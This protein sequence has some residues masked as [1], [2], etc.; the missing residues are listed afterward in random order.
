M[1]AVIRWFVAA[2][3]LVA[4]L[5]A[6]RPSPRP[7]GPESADSLRRA[8]NARVREHLAA[9][10]AAPSAHEHAAPAHAAA[11]AAAPAR[12]A[13]PAAVPATA[14]ALAHAGP[15]RAPEAATVGSLH[16]DGAETAWATWKDLIDGN[17]RFAQGKASS[18]PLVQERE[19][20]RAGQHPRA[21]V[22]GCADSRCP[23][24]LLFDQSLGDLFVV[25]TAGN[26]ADPVA[27]G[28]LEYAVEHLGVHLLVVLGH[29]ACGA[30]KATI[31]GGELP[32]D[33]LRAIVDHISPAVEAA[34]V[35]WAG[36]ELLDH[37][38]A[39]NA[40]QS[41]RDLLLRSPV[42]RDAVEKGHLKLVTAVYHFT[43]GRVAPLD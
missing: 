27:L 13:A 12:V 30:V 39:A 37:A 15:A 17:A 6:G 16:G 21:I 40:Q 2:T 42:L 19:S 23:P 31:A 25:R 10:P 38:I 4:T 1:P 14:E 20:L 43:D 26:I 7:L 11:P 9:I 8:V 5:A 22:L 18:R 3:I 33:N 28:S 32:S 29:D 24:E 35:H 36:D 34:R 41:A